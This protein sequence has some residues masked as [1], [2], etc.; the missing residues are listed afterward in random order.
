MAQESEVMVDWEALQEGSTSQMEKAALEIIK[1]GCLEK[2]NDEGLTP[3]MIIA[4]KNPLYDSF[5]HL[6]AALIGSE[7]EVVSD[8]ITTQSLIYFYRHATYL[9]IAKNLIEAG[10][11]VNARR[12]SASAISL[13][14]EN[15]H[16]SM[17]QKLIEAG[18]SIDSEDLE[19]VV[20]DGIKGPTTPLVIIALS[21]MKAS[22]EVDASWGG[23]L[24]Y[25][26]ESDVIP[27]IEA[28]RAQ[29]QENYNN[30]IKA[31]I[32]AG[33]RISTEDYKANLPLHLAARFSSEEVM[34]SVIRLNPDMELIN[35][36]A[37]KDERSDASTPLDE[38]IIFH[39]AGSA[40]ALL[41]AGVDIGYRDKYGNTALMRAA[42]YGSPEI[43]SALVNHGALLE[44]R[45]ESGDTA[46]MS[47]VFQEG[48]AN[49]IAL[50]NLGANIN[51][52]NKYG[53]TP[54]WEAINV[55]S[56][57]LVA[58]MIENGADLERGAMDGSYLS[59]LA[60]DILLGTWDAP[61]DISLDSYL[62]NYIG[63]TELLIEAGAE[64]K[65]S[66]CD[67]LISI[68]AHQLSESTN[69][70]SGRKVRKFLSL[71]IG[72]GAKIKNALI[73]AAKNAKDPRLL[74]ELMK[75][76]ANPGRKDDEG[77]TALDYAK[78]NKN[79]YKTDAYWELN[80]AFHNKQ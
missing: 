56:P 49:C 72:K 12:G 8:I 46:L 13:A 69:V 51:A 22:K 17:V 79:I 70:S 40:L 78:E 4:S 37:P 57:S 76:G 43:I 9:D 28:V 47:A 62:D 48:D 54:L 42:R 74:T 75:L 59:L 35:M 14:I 7:D 53:A 30:R 19:P 16:F 60:M 11:D 58:L 36:K 61:Y 44:S 71:Y 38:S 15:G 33:A 34:A 21:S 41:K 5:L 24:E 20:A 67:N 2:K 18:A 39:N 80:D 68:I 1:T 65:P 32:S 6:H 26:S 27:F 25:V 3:L 77:K 73:V 29:L 63:I 52:I 23:I 66:E 31:L 45:N 55:K 10:A 50:L 64:L